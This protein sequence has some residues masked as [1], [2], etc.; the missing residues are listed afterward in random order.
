[1]TIHRYGRISRRRHGLT[2]VTLMFMKPALLRF[3]VSRLLYRQPE[4]AIRRDRVRCLWVRSAHRVIRVRSVFSISVV[5]KR[6]SASTT[7][8]ERQRAQLEHA[9]IISPACACC[10]SSPNRHRIRSVQ[11]DARSGSQTHAIAQMRQAISVVID[12]QRAVLSIRR[13]EVQIAGERGFD[14]RAHTRTR[15]WVGRACRCSLI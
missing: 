14:G 1:M 10:A 3:G 12:A 5:A 13:L 11:P 15:R 2:E 6:L 8:L 4:L 9:K 7:E